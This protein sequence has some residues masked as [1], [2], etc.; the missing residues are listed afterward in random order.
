MATLLGYAG[1]NDLVGRPASDLWSDM[2]VR[3]KML[4]AL[5]EENKIIQWEVALHRKDR[6]LI[7]ISC[8]IMANY[9][10]K[11]EIAGFE[12]IFIDISTQKKLQNELT[13]SQEKFSKIFQV[14]PYTIVL[15]KLSDGTVLEVNK[16]F[17][18]KTGHLREEIIGKKTIDL[19]LWTDPTQREVMTTELREKGE[20]IMKEFGYTLKNGKQGTGVFS[21]RR[22]DLLNETCLL[23]ITQDFT[24]RKKIEMALQDSLEK[25]S[26]YAFKNAHEVR[27]PLSRII[28]LSN[29]LPKLE[30]DEEKT[31]TLDY[32]KSSALEL[33]KIVKEMNAIL[34]QTFPYDSP[35]DDS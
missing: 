9:D 28:S 27:G 17:E 21:A 4:T 6:S 12:G 14:I 20:V 3:T 30:N 31:M 13:H 16:G 7:D 24:E 25:I 33:D 11:G 2:S 34:A 23:F 1:V 15:S 18:E 29:V 10:S 5:K 8:S 35:R 26:M 19:N 32:L 22:I